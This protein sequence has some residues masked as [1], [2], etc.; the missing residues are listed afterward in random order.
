[1]KNEPN[2][3]FPGCLLDS[4]PPRDVVQ[5]SKVLF[6]K[7]EGLF[8]L[9]VLERNALKEIDLYVFVFQ[10][11]EPECSLDEN[12]AQ[13]ERKPN[14]GDRKPDQAIQE[15]GKTDQSV[16]EE[17]GPLSPEV[18]GGYWTVSI[19]MWLLLS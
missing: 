13:A 19:S 9:T 12:Q 17:R 11:P 1:M 2:L 7:N 15:D 5:D 3:L 14:K 8:P 4:S 16:S 10:K 18:S 6:H